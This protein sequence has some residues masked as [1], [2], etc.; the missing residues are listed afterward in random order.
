MQVKNTYLIL[1][2]LLLVSF[3]CKSSDKQADTFKKNTAKSLPIRPGAYQLHS[4]LPLL[5]GKRVAVVGNQ[6]SEI[7][8]VHLVD[9]LV[10]LQINIVKVFAPEHGFRGQASAGE[11]VNN[12]IDIKTGLPIISLYGKH[13][14]PTREDLKNVD[15][16]LFDIQDVGVRFYTYLSTLHYVLEAGAEHDIPVIVLDRPNPN[17]DYIDG[18]VMQSDF[19]SFVGLHPVP[20]VYAMTIG[21]YARMIN[22][23]HWLKNGVQ[24]TL[25]V[26][27]VQNY[28][29]GAVYKL[30][31]KPS[32]NL[33]NYQSVRLYPSLCLF[34]GTDVSVGRGTDFPFQ[35][36]GAPWLPD[37]G[38]K[39]IPRPNAASKWPKHQE[40]ICYGK[41]LKQITPPAEIHL[42]WLIETYKQCPDTL[43]Y[44]NG[45]FNRLAG[46]ETLQQMIKAGKNT[47]QIKKTWQNDLNEFKKIRSKYLIY[48]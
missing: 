4:Y 6:T 38:F 8:G 24:A 9:T 37:T 14:K 32:P 18:P 16:L 10:S 48:N 2:L 39:F 40:K 47:K 27:P 26:I 46:N 19:I 43:T 13:K 29:H 45:F 20:I 7:N 25:K 31:V 44:F 11:Q 41:D 21:E 15:V 1:I 17:S 30:P 22:G 36:Y 5:Q 33:P 35:V 34:E 12:S 23:E 28:Y 3:S 42:Q